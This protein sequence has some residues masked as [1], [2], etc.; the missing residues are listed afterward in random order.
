MPKVVFV[1]VALLVTLRLDGGQI[2]IP[3][4]GA[5]VSASL[6]VAPSEC[7]PPD[8]PFSNPYG[9]AIASINT[10]ASAGS[11]GVFLLTD[12]YAN[13]GS[14]TQGSGF[15]R[16]VIN[17]V[18]GLAEVLFSDQAI[19]FGPPQGFLDVT[20]AVRVNSDDGSGSASFSIDGVGVG[21]LTRNSVQ[22]VLHV[23]FQSGQPISFS[24]IAFGSAFDFDPN[25]PFNGSAFVTS[26]VSTST[27]TVLDAGG[28]RVSDFSYLTM[29]GEPLPFADGQ[30][31]VPEPSTFFLSG[32]GLAALA[33]LRRRHQRAKPAI[34]SSRSLITFSLGHL[35]AP[36]S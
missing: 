3:V 35:P 36:S 20:V 27:F 5:N 16:L 4:S 30:W 29:S 21:A 25:N 23:P 18:G 32:V 10:S 26:T 13:S 1:G 11:N 15:P 6:C 7:T 28:Q 34:A 8:R 19:I 14:F 33:L 17:S 9:Y 2:T 31:I 22:R 24:G 12:V